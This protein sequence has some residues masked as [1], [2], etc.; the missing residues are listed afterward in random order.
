MQFLSQ[1][2]VQYV[3]RRK[4]EAYYPDCLIPIIKFGGGSVVIWESISAAGVGALYICDGTTNS[5]RYLT[6]LEKVLESSALKLCNGDDREYY[7]QQDNAPCH[8]PYEVTCWFAES[9]VQVLDWPV[10]SPDLY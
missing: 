7:F 3:R 8:T 5:R 1:S 2:D 9:D 10:Q 6:M 4:T